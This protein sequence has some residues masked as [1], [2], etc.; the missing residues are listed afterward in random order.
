MMLSSRPTIDGISTPSGPSIFQRKF[1][2]WLRKPPLR[3]AGRRLLTS[4]PLLFVVSAISFLLV[5]LTPGN[6]AEDI[7][8][9]TGT[10]QE[11]AKLRQSFGLNLP[12][13]DQ[14]WR[15]LKKALHGDLGR[16]LLTSQSVTQMIDVRLPVTLW[17]IVGALALTAIVGVPLG[18]LSATRGGVVGRLVDGASLVGFAL[19]SFWIGALLIVLF[20]V[21]VHWFPAVGYVPLAQAPIQWLR[22]LVLPVI[23]LALPGIAWVARQTREA[24]LD[25]LASEYI[26]MARANGI[27]PSS[28]LLRHALKPVSIRV[29]TILGLQAVGLLGGTVLIETVFGLPGLGSLA[30]TATTEHDLP[31]VQGIAIYFTVIVVVINLAIDLAYAWLNPR[32]RT[33]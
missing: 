3:V 32:V 5:S 19:P 15:W 11:Y 33:A 1:L 31:V 29:L 8:G 21:D 16:S 9:V 18:A 4:I 25:V 22:S 20:A 30:V 27:S 26:R 12:L 24:M 13:Y 2:D 6:A 7:L 23:A 10:L 17:L 28:I 14:Y